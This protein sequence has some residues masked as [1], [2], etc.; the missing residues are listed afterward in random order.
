M[1]ISVGGGIS[2]QE[3]DQSL[4]PVLDAIDRLDD[5]VQRLAAILKDI[6]VAIET[7][8][9]VLESKLNG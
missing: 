1:P 5:N 8:T 7:Q 4:K 3:M 9:A 2:K 6:Q